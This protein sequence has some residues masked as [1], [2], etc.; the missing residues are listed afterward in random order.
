MKI[1]IISVGKLKE[2]G[3]S[4]LVDEYSKRLSKYAVINHIEVKDAPISNDTNKVLKEEGDSILK[5]IPPN[6]FVIV[7]ALEG[8][9][10]NSTDFS[11]LIIDSLNKGGANLTLIIGGS[12]GLDLEVKKRANYLYSF[13][14]LTFPHQLMKVMVLEQV[15][16]AFKIYSNEQYHK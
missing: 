7:F 1:N 13:S 12:L 10:T 5:K 14:D 3:F 6:S 8:K 4:L 15:Y 16:R 11:N 9:K 2:K